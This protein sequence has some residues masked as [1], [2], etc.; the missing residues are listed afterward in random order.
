MTHFQNYYRLNTTIAFLYSSK[1]KH[2]LYLSSLVHRQLLF[3]LITLIYL[4][5][6]LQLHRSHK[7]NLE[8]SFFLI[9][10]NPIS[11]LVVCILVSLLHKCYYQQFQDL[12][13]HYI[14]FNLVYLL[15]LTIKQQL[16]Y[17]N[18]LLLRLKSDFLL[19]SIPN[20]QQ[21]TQCLLQSY[22]QNR[23]RCYNPFSLIYLYLQKH[24]SYNFR[25]QSCFPLYS[26]NWNPKS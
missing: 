10:I 5:L 25:I 15:Y 20:F 2:D 3:C 18:L 23:T 4:P 21:Q 11:I 14:I 22:L 16:A 1:M 24:Q 6:L 26:I 12:L 19:H 8:D 9:I 17:D 13:D 7:F